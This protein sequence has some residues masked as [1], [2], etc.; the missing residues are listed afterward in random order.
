MEP[1][2]P[3]PGAGDDAIEGPGQV[4]WFRRAAGPGREHE[5]VRGPLVRKATDDPHVGLLAQHIIGDA[6]QW[7]L[8]ATG[9]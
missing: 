5:L 8:P 1:D 2:G 6:D 3:K 4:A 9:G 7:K